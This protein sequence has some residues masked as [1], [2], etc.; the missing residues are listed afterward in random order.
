MKIRLD[1]I[2][3]G[4][5]CCLATLGAG[6]ASLGDTAT[7]AKSDLDTWV[8]ENAVSPGIHQ[9]A[10]TFFGGVTVNQVTGQFDPS[11]ASQPARLGTD[12]IAFNTATNITPGLAATRYQVN[13]VTMKATWT[14]DSDPN[15]LFY[16]TSPVSQQQILSEVVNGTPS[17]QKPMEL[18]GAALRDGYTGY[19][20]GVGTTA[21]PPLYDEGTH[22]YSGAN[23]ESVVYPIVGSSTQAGSYVDVSNSVTGGYSETDP[24]HTTTPFTPIP[25]SIGKTNLNVG[26]A[27]PDNTTFTFTLDLTQPGVKSYVQQSLHN[28]ALALMLSTLTSTGEFGSGGGYPRWLMKESAGFPYNEPASRLPQLT[29]AYAILPAGVAGDFNGN[30][31]VD[32][33]DY[34]LWRNGGALQN[35]ISSPGVDDIQDYLDWRVN[36]GHTAGAGSSLGGTVAVPEPGTLALMIIGAFG[37]RAFQFGR[38]RACMAAR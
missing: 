3:V 27:I 11:T 25:W 29:I 31:V 4:I 33:A 20:F 32:M 23:G 35:E 18:Y 24:L 21:G 30:G 8:Y 22:P 26:D 12:L 2:V 15:Q 16:S 37:L 6:Q 38:S 7:W 9:L 34:V 19:E 36:F 14:Y 28:G 17:R 10:P 5:V 1:S 13:S